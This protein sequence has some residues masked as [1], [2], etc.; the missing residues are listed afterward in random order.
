MN[1]ASSICMYKQCQWPGVR[2]DDQQ[3][4]SSGCI[5]IHVCFR[6]S[7][8]NKKHQSEQSS[9]S[10]DVKSSLLCDELC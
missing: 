6:E 3:I 1:A 2:G 7:L 8:C 5:I 4:L 10:V 9:I